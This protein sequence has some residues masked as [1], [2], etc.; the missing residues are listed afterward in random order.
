MAAIVLIAVGAL[1]LL[2]AVLFGALVEMYRDVRQL[3]DAVGILDR[4]TVVEIG[5]VEGAMP[6]DYGLP[7][8]L[9]SAPFAVILFVS[10]R[11]MACRKIAASLGRPLP[12]GLWVVVEAATAAGAEA[13]L[14]AFNLRTIATDGRLLVD[15][16]GRIAARLGLNMSPV[17]FRV[18]QGRLAS[19]TTIPSPRYLVS[20]LPEPLRLRSVS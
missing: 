18:E 6:S 10:D 7:R 15:V 13:F 8:A 1:A 2:L 4:P 5:D 12:R 17:G 16:E 14:D 9:D 19:A 11:C 20:I 3:R